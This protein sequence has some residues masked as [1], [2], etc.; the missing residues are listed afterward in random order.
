MRWKEKEL[1][2]HNEFPK[3][4]KDNKLSHESMNH[5]YMRF[6]KTLKIKLWKLLPSTINRKVKNIEKK[7]A[8][9]V[10]GL[11]DKFSCEVKNQ[12]RVIMVAFKNAKI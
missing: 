5:G 9:G 6:M 1:F 4:N 10:K 7:I 3:F 8:S 12:T 11:V 2:S